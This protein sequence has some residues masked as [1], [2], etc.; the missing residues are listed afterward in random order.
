MAYWEVVKTKRATFC[1]G[2]RR[3]IT[4]GE[5]ALTAGWATCTAGRVC[6]DCVFRL[7]KVL[8][9]HNKYKS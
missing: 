6:E 5:Y 1:Q 2:C 4:K 3:D 8:T 7:F 9:Y